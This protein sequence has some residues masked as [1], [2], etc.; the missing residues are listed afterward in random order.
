M[1]NYHGDWRTIC[2]VVDMMSYIPEICRRGT[3]PEIVRYNSVSLHEQRIVVT[4][5]TNFVTSF[6]LHG[7]PHKLLR[8]LSIITGTSGD[9]PA[10]VW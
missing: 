10:N 3:E 1:R 8:I 2:A 6:V 5:D 7:R 4:K 9:N